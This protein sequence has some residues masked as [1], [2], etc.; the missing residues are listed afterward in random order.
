MKILLILPA[1][2]H[3]RVREVNGFVPKRK[4]LRFSVLSLTTLAALTPFEHEVTIC[5]EN[6]EAVDLDAD[7]DIVGITFMTG[8]AARA[9]ELAAHF[10]NRGIITV[11]G[12]FH[13]SLCTEEATRHFD[14]V[15]AGQAEGV[16]DRVLEDIQAGSF[17]N[18]YRGD[19]DIDLATVPV[20]RRDLL[21]KTSKYYVTT[22]AVQ[23]G[24]GCHHKCRFCSVTAFFQHTHHSR[25]LE[26]V[27]EELQQIP[28]NFMFVD[29]NIIADT[30]Y[31]KALFRGMIPMKKRWISQ[32]SIEIADDPELLDLAYKAGCRGVFIGIESISEEN[33]AAMDKGFNDSRGY[34]R[35]IRKI[36]QKGIGVQA[37]VIVGL[38]RDDTSAFE[39]TLRFLQKAGI[40]ALQLAIL[41]PLPGTP[42]YEQFKQEGRIIDEN[43]AHYDYRHTVIQPKRMRPEQLQAGADWLYAQFYRLDRIILR[44]IRS[45]FTVGL[46]PTWLSW[47]LNLTYRY[48]NKREGIVGWNP[49]QKSSRWYHFLLHRINREVP[50]L[51]S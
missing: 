38:D 9:Y 28:Q 1:A 14:I 39:R 11:A 43:W 10:R 30:D 40:N 47:K 13:P 18:V 37:G 50:Q 22:N 32:C 3:L 6:V 46:I 42:L 24:R 16:W 27:L 49:A 35:R 19:P 17:Q 31:A 21:R 36:H 29:D 48:N 23:T 7:V 26:H 20:P 4:M 8:L 5:D 34:Y 12:G 33:L 41:T 2:E 25:P 15:V 51:M 44:S 45:L